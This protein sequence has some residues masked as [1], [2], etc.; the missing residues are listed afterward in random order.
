[1][2]KTKNYLVIVEDKK[3]KE[4]HM[5]PMSGI[6]TNAVRRTIQRIGDY[7]VL[8]ITLDTPY[9]RKLARVAMKRGKFKV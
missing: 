5:P 3:T 4:R 7:K 2:T 9:W 8:D 1:M 6:N